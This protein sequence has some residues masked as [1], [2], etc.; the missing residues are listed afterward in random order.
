MI[1]LET[2]LTLSNEK[3]QQFRA[4]LKS[5]I[6]SKKSLGAYIEQLTG[7]EISSGGNGIPLL[8]KDNIQVKGWSTT[9]CTNILKGYI[10]PY[11]A[12]VITKL[13]A[14]NISPFG[15]A[16]MDELAMGNTGESSCYGAAKNPH[17]E[18]L[19]A[20]GSSSGSAAAVAGKI[21]I[22]ALA[23]DT[24]GSIRQPASFCGC[25]GFK[26][27]Y[28]RVS[29]YGLAALSSSLDQIGTITQNVK[30]SALLFDTIAGYDKLDNTSIDKPF[31]PTAPNLNGSKKFKIGVARNFIDMC[32]DEVKN[33]INSTIEALKKAGHEIVDIEIKNADTHIASYYIISTA[34]GS[35][36]LNRLDGIRYGARVDGSDIKEIYQNTRTKGFGKE[37]KRRILL[38]TFALSSGYY[39]A[40]YTKAQKVRT[41]IKNQMSEIYK[42]CDLIIAP[43]TPTVAYKL[44][45]KRTP[46]ESYKADIFTLFVNL[47]GLPAISVPVHKEGLP[48]GMQ[49]VGKALDDQS[50]LDLAYQVEQL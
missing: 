10:A 33:P 1:T 35:T 4:D 31:T 39:D 3:L 29:R 48:V 41:V 46:L 49:I 13:K 20:G 6:E 5:S 23:S 16:N 21:A 19:I 38:G 12:T 22:A 43:V 24:G 11:D 47:A 32:D 36:G 18:S 25:V 26:P 7:E 37:V 2:A 42:I 28:G 30:D 17:D 34:E 15:R 40:Y 44:G 45:T 50:V 8:I 9:G 14:A 27:T